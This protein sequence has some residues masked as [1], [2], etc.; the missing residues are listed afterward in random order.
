VKTYLTGIQAT[1][2]PHLG[3]LLGA[4]KPA[5]DFANSK[6]DSQRFLYFIAD[7]HALTSVRDPQKFSDDTYQVA[8]TWMALG[9]N[10]EN[11]I[12]YKQS[13]IPEI[14]ELA[15]I[16]SCHTPKG[17]LNRAHS[18]K[19]KRQANEENGKNDLD[20]GVNA[21]LFNYPVLMASDILLFDTNIVPVGKDQVQHIEIARSMAQ[22][23]NQYYG[24]TLVEPQESL[25]GSGQYIPGLD[26]RKMSKSYGNDIPLFVPEKRLKKLINKIKTDSREPHE[27][28][29]VKDS[30]IFELYSC[31]AN[32]DEKKSLAKR[33]EEGISWGEA[34]A[35]LFEKVNDYLVEP[36]EKFNHLMEN[37]SLIDK[38][39][40][41]GAQKA[42]EIS[43]EVLKRIKKNILNF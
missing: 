7:Y 37:R 20:H 34:K 9:L 6:N 19:A 21:G 24:P 27:P 15:W 43:S 10:T 26:G 39:L 38:E 29:D 23:I 18:Y 32:E 28:K 3:N 5:I 25:S 4:I 16:L 17:D 11:A 41:L 12:F 8:A 30:L 33:Y 36:R 1:G 13:D 31:F 42:R 2:M 14:F 40:K 35:T 22:R